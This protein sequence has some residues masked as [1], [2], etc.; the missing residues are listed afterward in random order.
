MRLKIKKMLNKIMIM[1]YQKK[2]QKFKINELYSML[3]N[4]M[5]M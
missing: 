5:L 3:I 1:K 2:F 4:E